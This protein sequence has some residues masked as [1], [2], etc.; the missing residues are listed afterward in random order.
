MRN[1]FRRISATH[2]ALA[3]SVLAVVSRLFIWLTVDFVWEDALITLR[4]VK[5]IIAGNGF[6]YNLGEHVLGTTTPG[7]AV[8]LSTFGSMG[9]EPLLTARIISLLSDA[10]T[11]Y[12][13]VKLGIAIKKPNIGI[14]AALLLALWPT[15]ITYAVSGMETSLATALMLMTFIAYSE[16]RP[17]L[18]MCLS[19]LVVLTRPDGMIL[20]CVLAA[21]DFLSRQHHIK[22]QHWALFTGI[23]LPWIIFGTIY[24]G[25]PIPNT[26]I[27]KSVTNRLNALTA[28]QFNTYVSGLVQKLLLPV[29]FLGTALTVRR[30]PKLLPLTAWYFIHNTA[31]ILAGSNHQWHYR[32]TSPVYFLL[33]AIGIS[34]LVECVVS[35]LGNAQNQFLASSSRHAWGAISIILAFL[36]SV[37][38]IPHQ[39]TLLQQQTCL[40]GNRKAVGLWLQHNTAK[41]ATVATEPIGYIGFYA[42]RRMIDFPGLISPQVLPIYR[43]GGGWFEVIS[44]LRPTHIVLREAEYRNLQALLDRT[45]VRAA[46]FQSRCGAFGE[47]F[48]ILRRRDVIA[49]GNQKTLPS[50]SFNAEARRLS[51]ANQ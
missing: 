49:E 44:R 3:I 43:G 22:W 13:L 47:S 6:V 15:N 26:I 42:N 38:L 11:C 4:Y 51:V 20:V 2:I 33:I 48:I 27:A 17:G 35:R 45:Y 10:I 25:S 28:L 14:I 37:N 19:G 39:A 16:R 40:N 5:N 46:E 36:L 8:I 29:L 32:V 41:D 7:F 18:A 9:I 31:F 50:A 30:F 23:L 1:A 12:L 34:F 24:F 21:Y